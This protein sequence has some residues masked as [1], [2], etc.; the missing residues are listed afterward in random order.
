M[1]HS[2]TTLLDHLAFPEGPR[3]HDGHFYFSDMHDHRVVRI[4][5]DGSASTVCEV[6]GQPSGLGWLPDGQM[7]RAHV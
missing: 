5:D 2:P 3:W 1:T 6:P 4:E 7:G